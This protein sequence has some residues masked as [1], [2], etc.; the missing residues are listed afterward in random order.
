ME[1]GVVLWLGRQSLH[2]F[3]CTHCNNYSKIQ[4]HSMLQMGMRYYVRTYKGR[5][6]V[7]TYVHTQVLQLTYVYYQVAV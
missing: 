6:E 7:C 4:K 5:E 3:F 2:C 1:G